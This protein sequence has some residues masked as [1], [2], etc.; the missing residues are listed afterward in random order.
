[1]R[2]CSLY[3][4]SSGNSIYVG[5]ENTHI[6]V[7]VGVSA[8]K[9]IEALTNLEIKPEEIDGILVTHEQIGRAHV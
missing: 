4:G 9:I 8:K 5:S 1:M 2:L 7:D 6:L 3:S